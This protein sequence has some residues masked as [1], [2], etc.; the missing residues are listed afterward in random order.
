MREK[1]QLNVGWLK[2]AAICLAL[3]GFLTTED[4]LA[5]GSPP[6][7][8]VPPVGVSVQKGGTIILTSVIALSFTPVTV[9]WLVNSNEVKNG[10]VVTVTAP[11][12]GTT[13]TTLTIPN[14]SAAN[15]GAYQLQVQNGGG[16]VVSD[17]ATVLVLGDVV[18]NLVTTVTML[19]SQCKLTGNGFQLQ[20][21]KPA[22]SNC[23]IEATT[24][25][26]H[27][28]P[29]YTDNS[30]STNV[31]YVDTAATGLLSRYYRARLQ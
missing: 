30:S 10:T 31:S 13:T 26:V 11:I 8:T 18:S 3:I 1:L 4:V 19:P 25:F 28:T 12:T 6:W 2:N 7:I 27:W 17:P 23:V 15:A 24:D 21:I 14:A 16:Q 22:Q 29:I 9:K 20:L 5:N